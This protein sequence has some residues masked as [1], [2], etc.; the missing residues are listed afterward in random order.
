[1][2][3][4][5]SKQFAYA[6]F[7]K[8]CVP[9]RIR[10]GWSGPL[11]IVVREL[12]RNVRPITGIE[13]LK[14]LQTLFAQ[15]R[16][17]FFC[18]TSARFANCLEQSLEID[19]QLTQ[20]VDIE[21]P[22]FLRRVM[23]SL[24]GYQVDG[25]V[26]LAGRQRAL[27]LDEMG[28]GKTLQAIAASLLLKRFA[29][30]ESCLLVVPKSVMSHWKSEIRRF[31]T[32]S[33]TQVVAG[34]C[35]RASQ[36]RANT[37]FKLVTL[38]T[39][40]RDFPC[41]GD[42]QLVI[43]DEVHKARNIQ[44]IASRVLRN[45]DAQYFFGLSGTPI[46]NS[47]E[48]LYNLLRILRCGSL[49][50]PLEFTA[51]HLI[52]DAFGKAKQSLH[53]E[54]FFVRHADRVLRRLKKNVVKGL[55]QMQCEEVEL[56]LTPLQE[57]MAAPLLSELEMLCRRLKERYDLEDF[58][59]RRWLVNR[60]VELSDSTAL[61]DATTNESSKL[62]WLRQF[63]TEQCIRAREKVVVFTRWTRSQQIIC[64]LCTQ[65]DI[66]WVSLSGGNTGDEREQAVRQFSQD[67]E[68]L[69]FIST[70]AGGVGINLQAARTIVN[71]EPAWNPSTDAQRLQRVHRIGQPW[72]V[73][74]VL[75]T[76]FLDQMF[77]R[78][79]HPRKQYGADRLDALSNA[80]MV[81][82]TPA[83]EEIVPVIDFLRASVGSD[84]QLWNI[85]ESPSSRTEVLD[86]G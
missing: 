81:A 72:E 84:A 70:D 83:W 29:K 31:C 42:H 79:T 3:L 13:S 48:D 4:L 64:K 12:V 22:A 52:C 39:L 18:L 26:F 68:T 78:I 43:V 63:L 6:W 73:R 1:M 54:L 51:T 71:F 67:R 37:F 45:L 2:A 82:V 69:V 27:L 15:K 5:E 24:Y 85:P 9:P 62:T 30:I 16:I 28:L 55:P 35:K 33:I 61:L 7:D 47:L 46:E 36:Y 65:L 74:A 41:I 38:E 49:E 20:L 11:D 66:K 19:A 59:R 76:T 10:I 21:G 8:A 75:P 50:S 23:P 40:R 58:L 77:V 57:Q 80:A 32:E 34:P 14:R 25:A 60:L 17:E 56:P 44:T 86:E 53:S